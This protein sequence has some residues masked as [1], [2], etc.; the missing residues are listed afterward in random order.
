MIR[1]FKKVKM[2]YQSFRSHL[3]CV[4]LSWLR[5]KVFKLNDWQ[6]ELQSLE[7]FWNICW[8]LFEALLL[9]VF[10]DSPNILVHL[11][12]KPEC[13]RIRFFKASFSHVELTIMA[14][15]RRFIQNHGFSSHYVRC[16]HGDVHS[17]RFMANHLWWF[18]LDSYHGS[19]SML[20]LITS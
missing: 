17:C 12:V 1:R 10:Y 20:S 18:N 15:S 3:W 13:T 8:R 9:S 2:F 19:S 16:I 4:K 5:R 6:A 7:V 14:H 11:E